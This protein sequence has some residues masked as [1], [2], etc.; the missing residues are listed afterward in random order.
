MDLPGKL[1]VSNMMQSTPQSR[2]EE[3]LDNANA[4]IFQL[5]LAAVKLPTEWEVSK[6]VP[7]VK[8]GALPLEAKSCNNLGRAWEE[9][10][11]IKFLL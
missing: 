11:I 5:S 2:T 6:I 1:F 9:K 3:I 8:L 4:Y 7:F 10:G